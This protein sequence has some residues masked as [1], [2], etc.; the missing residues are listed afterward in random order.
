MRKN[1]TWVRIYP[2]PFR[3]LDEQEQY[4]KYDWIECDLQRSAKDKRPE[5]SH[6]TDVKQLV[7]A[8]HIGT[9]DQWRERRRIFLKNG[10]VFTD[11]EALISAAKANEMSLATFKP[12]QI[13]DFVW[14]EEEER[15]WDESKLENMR[16]MTAQG[17]LFDEAWRETFRVIPKMPYA[18]SYRFIDLAGKERKLQVFDWEVG[19]LFAG[20]K[21]RANGDEDVAL[22]KVRRKYFD[23]FTKTDLHF[24]LGTTLAWHSVAPNPWVIIGVLPIPHERQQELDLA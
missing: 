20:C 21:R 14:K 5:S 18:F 6:P 4:K 17:D 13:L 8:G 3:R 12:Q 15:E 11:M 9:E 16:A 7:P 24:V 10:E 22:Q 19:A 1:G 2:V 23:E